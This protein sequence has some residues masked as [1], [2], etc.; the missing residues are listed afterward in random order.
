MVS[1]INSVIHR[2]PFVCCFIR[3]FEKWTK[4]DE[5]FENTIINYCAVKIL[6]KKKKKD[7]CKNHKE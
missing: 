5:F 2:V 1:F 6:N 7:V 3:C 4:F